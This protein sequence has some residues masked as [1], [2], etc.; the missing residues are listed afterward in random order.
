MYKEATRCIY[1]YREGDL[2]V[3]KGEYEAGQRCKGF[4]DRD[5]KYLG[6][7]YYHFQTLY[8]K[9]ELKLEGALLA[10]MKEKM[11]R[12]EFN[13]KEAAKN[14]VV[15]K[16]TVG[17]KANEFLFNLSQLADDGFDAVSA[18]EDMKILN[19]LP[20]VIDGVEKYLFSLW[21]IS[22][23]NSR[24]PETIAGF[25][26]LVGV[27]AGR[28]SRWQNSDT[29]YDLYTK[30][31]KKFMAQHAHMVDL[32]LLSKCMSGDNTAI[33]TYY[34]HFPVAKE[35]TKPKGRSKEEIKEILNIKN[36]VIVAAKEAMPEGVVG[37]LQTEVGKK[38]AENALH[39]VVEGE[40]VTDVE[41]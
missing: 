5:R 12:F 37:R 23:V 3:K 36:A 40:V 27:S 38:L 7:C 18:Y 35:E 14:K 26:D 29:I 13:K 2:K 10:E 39:K 17:S 28:L 22:P 8:R 11:E 25:S 41:Q 21:L 16:K 1:I 6:Y 15:K 34:E 9:G 24:K 31:R 32:L 20:S 4:P 30:H 19:P 33:R